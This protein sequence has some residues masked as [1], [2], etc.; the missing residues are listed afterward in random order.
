MNKGESTRAWSRPC[1]LGFLAIRERER[2]SH[3]AG[4]FVACGEGCGSG[5]TCFV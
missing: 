1:L 2:E 4:E 3:G 5:G